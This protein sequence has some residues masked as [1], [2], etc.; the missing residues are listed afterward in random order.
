[1]AVE[2][3]VVEDST[4]IEGAADSTDVESDELA[5][6]VALTVGELSGGAGWILLVV[7]WWLT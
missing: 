3:L 2:G 6:D 5:N 1:M 7:A 4:A